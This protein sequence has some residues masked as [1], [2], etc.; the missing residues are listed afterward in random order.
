MKTIFK[1]ALLSLV[2][3]GGYKFLSV[4]P[5]PVIVDTTIA[6]FRSPAS[7]TTLTEEPKQQPATEEPIA[8]AQEP[9]PIQQIMDQSYNEI[10][11][12]KGKI[13]DALKSDQAK[14]LAELQNVLKRNGNGPRLRFI[15]ETV[16]DSTISPDAKIGF[17][18]NNLEY[19]NQ[20]QSFEDNA[21]RLS[22][23]TVLINA[24][25]DIHEKEHIDPSETVNEI[26][27]TEK[28]EYFGKILKE[29]FVGGQYEETNS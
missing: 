29:Q 27:S 25:I 28:D 2:I 3:V 12:Q 11:E 23:N 8:L 19:S 16:A 20:D 24:L 9:D 13:L 4:E 10:L 5:Q 26:I 6:S 18:R 14:T 7:V 17:I 21:N 1:L 22:K 15:L